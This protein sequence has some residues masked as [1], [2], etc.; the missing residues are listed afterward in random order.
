MLVTVNSHLEPSPALPFLVCKHKEV[1]INTDNKLVL[2]VVVVCLF[3]FIEKE[4]LCATA[5]AVLELSL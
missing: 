5:L 4:F 1:H 3:V 2:F